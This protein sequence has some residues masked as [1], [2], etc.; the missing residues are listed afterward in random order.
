MT[1]DLFIDLEELLQTNTPVKL[2]YNT[3]ADPKPGEYVVSI[4]AGRKIDGP[5]I[6]CMGFFIRDHAKDHVDKLLQNWIHTEGI[7]CSNVN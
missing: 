3:D 2:Y 6:V 4:N 5:F 7:F 1:K